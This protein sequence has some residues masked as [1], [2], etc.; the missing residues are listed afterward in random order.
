MSFIIKGFVTI[1]N[2]LDGIMGNVAPLGELSSYS[3]T[4]STVKT[5]IAKKEYENISVDIFSCKEDGIIKS[6]PINTDTYVLALLED[7]IESFE[8]TLEFTAQFNTRHP[9]ATLI[10]LGNTIEYNGELLPSRIE[11]SATIDGEPCVFKL[12]FSDAVFRTEYDEYEIRVIPPIPNPADLDVGYN[13]M[14]SILEDYEYSVRVEAIEVA[15]GTDPCTKIVTLK[16]KWTDPDTDFSVD[17]IW[18]LIVYGNRGLIYTNQIEAIKKYLLDTTGRLPGDWTDWMPDLQIQAA[19]TI[20]PLW[21]KVALRST[22]SIEY[23]HSPV[24]SVSDINNACAL[25]YGRAFTA[26]EMAETVYT[27][28]T[29]KSTGFVVFPEP[30][31]G[32]DNK[33][34]DLYEDYALISM[35]DINVNR[36][37]EN[38]RNAISAIEQGIRLAEVD[39]GTQTLPSTFQ[40]QEEDGKHYLVYV[41]NGAIHRVMTK[42]SYLA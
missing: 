13:T 3:K 26:E 42:A 37:S 34:L 6:M 40:R 12:W 2:M 20:I 15:R 16:M 21:N 33:F 31:T 11:F 7:I 14:L 5:E 38:T 30:D 28:S 29:Y 19:L 17:I 1:N 8:S 36:L 27:V 10:A 25:R 18:T 24:V 32:E 4:F 39:T 35:N 22:G 23:V 41:V 9:D